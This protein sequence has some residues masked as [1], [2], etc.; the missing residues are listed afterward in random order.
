LIFQ[1][2]CHVLTSRFDGSTLERAALGANAFATATQPPLNPFP[3][4]S[5]HA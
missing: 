3:A 4:S 2:L 1:I 5:S